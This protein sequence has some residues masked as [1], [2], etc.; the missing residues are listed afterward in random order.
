MFLNMSFIKLLILLS[1]FML[2]LSTNDLNPQLLFSNIKTAA[3]IDTETG[4]IT[5]I[6]SGIPRAISIDYHRTKG[7]IYWS[8]VTVRSISRLKYPFNNRE[9]AEVIIT[10]DI[11]TPDGIAIDSVNDHLYWTDTGIDKVMRSNLDGSSRTVILDTNLQE[12]RAIVLDE[13][14]SMMYLSDWGT[15]PKIEKC[16]LDGSNR[17]TIVKEDLL[18]PNGLALD[19]NEGRIYWIDGGLHQIKSTKLDGSDMQ[20]ILKDSTWLPHP[21]DIEVYGSF[22]YY[23]DWSLYGV[24][25]VSK[26]SNST[27]A[28]MSSQLLTPMGIKIYHR[29]D[30]FPTDVFLLSIEPYLEEGLIVS[31]IFGTNSNNLEPVFKCIF[32]DTGKNYLYNIYWYINEI[33]VKTFENVPFADI[34]STWLR[35]IHWVGKFIM[36]MHVKCS[37]RAREKVNGTASPHQFSPVYV[38]GVI[39]DRFV[40]EVSE[41]RNLTLSLTCTVPV[42]CSGSILLPY[43]KETF[44]IGYPSYTKDPGPCSGSIQ[45]GD[46]A[47][48]QQTC[49]VVVPSRGWNKTLDVIVYGYVDNLYNTKAVRTSNIKLSHI[50]SNKDLSGAWDRVNIPNI[51]IRIKDIDT[52]L[53]L[54]KCESWSDPR[55]YTFNRKY[56]SKALSGEYILY[57]HKRSPYW[58]HTLS[59]ACWD[60]TCNVGVAIRS[61]SSLFVV[62]TSD[63]VSHQTVMPGRTHPFVNFRDCDDQNMSVKRIGTQYMVTLPSGTEIWFKVGKGIAGF[64]GYWIW[65]LTIKPSVLDIDQTEGL[66]GFLSNDNSKADDFKERETGNVVDEDKFIKSWFVPDDSGESLFAAD[67]DI[68]NHNEYL[69]PFC[70]CDEVVQDRQTPIENG[71]NKVKCNLSQPLEPCI[72]RTIDLDTSFYS[73]CSMSRKRRDLLYTHKE[74]TKRLRRNADDIDDV[75]EET[76]LRYVSDFVPKSFRAVP[77]WKNG[78]TEDSARSACN[79]GFHN[80][81]EIAKCMTYANLLTD[82]YITACIEDIKAA[83]DTSLMMMTIDKMIASCIMEVSKNES[84]LTSTDV[85]GEQSQMKTIMAQ[86][87]YNNCSG[88]GNCENGGCICE[89]GYRGH[90]CSS[91]NTAP[92]S[93]LIIPNAGRCSTRERQCLKTN[94]YGDFEATEVW[95]KIRHFQII[96][97]TEEHSEVYEIR[98]AEYK[99]PYMV[100]CHLGISRMKKSTKDAIIAEGYYISFSIDGTTFGDYVTF[101]MYDE[102]C[103]ACNATTVFCELL[104]TCPTIQEKDST[105]SNRDKENTQSSVIIGSVVGGV[106]FVVAVLC[107]L[108]YKFKVKQITKTID[109]FEECNVNNI[110]PRSFQYGK[111]VSSISQFDLHIYDN[112]PSTPVDVFSKKLKANMGVDLT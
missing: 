50:P 54:T 95:Y 93:G 58:V 72:N 44:K 64:T 4:N 86:L 84:L 90:D 52:N 13:A 75:T 12:P 40:Y 30:D 78:W 89:R 22:L 77:A 15:N 56:F 27:P 100:T 60:G 85:N 99:N 5:I 41:G 103:Y 16:M 88:H 17:R 110:P 61:H 97:Y 48:Q 46:L 45:G 26:L 87:C 98:K 24:F 55:Y 106:I 11:H 104:E 28:A 109:Y 47:F 82:E 92:P 105:V 107:G 33:Q 23:S 67:P 74:Q 37:L 35:P 21:F 2:I 68:L 71:F 10:D 38:A 6:A 81:S 8:D 49:G 3:I 57:R 63:V 31:N 65:H 96:N 51:Q 102:D 59:T 101:I 73:S 53:E 83:G 91:I 29:N 80:I 94:V 69:Q 36:N 62:R 39:P 79:D 20:L 42:G 1:R 18:W 32:S 25:K 34:H 70:V 111:E 43:C 14:N 19:F 9:V 66:C 112:K 108:L 7:F 76:F